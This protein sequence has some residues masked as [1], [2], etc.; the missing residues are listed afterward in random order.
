[1][2]IALIGEFSGVHQYLAAG[3]RKLGHTVLVVSDGDGYK[4]F[5]R[6]IDVNGSVNNKY[7]NSL[8]RIVKEIL[9]T[10]RIKNYDVVQFINPIAFFKYGPLNILY[11]KIASNNGKLFLLAA[12][13]DT[14]FWKAYRNGLYKYSPHEGLL[15]DKNENKSQWEKKRYIQ[16]TDNLISLCVGVIPC[17]PEYQIAYSKHP[18]ARSIIPFPLNLEDIEFKEMF[19]EKILSQKLSFFHGMHKKRYGAKGSVLIDKTMKKLSSKYSADIDY[20]SA[21]SIPFEQYLTIIK[22]VQIVIDQSHSYSPAMNSLISM[23]K[24]KI[25][26]GGCED[27]YM[28]SMGITEAPLINIKPNEKSIISQVEFL[29]ENKKSL[30]NYALRGRKYVEDNHDYIS[31]AKKYLNEWGQ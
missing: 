14:Y 21:E 17:I 26:M 31:V 12:G 16:L 7:F 30:R 8:N 10:D 3:L 25:V 19:K 27:E 22:N 20:F 29:L 11:K 28:C 9:A 23:A 6:D 18:K 4:N 2:R 13:T 1:M 24:G 15:K 5:K